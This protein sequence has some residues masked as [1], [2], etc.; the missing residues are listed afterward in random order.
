[1]DEGVGI[2]SNMAYSKPICY[3][4]AAIITAVLDGH[5]WA[6]GRDVHL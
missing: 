5:K 6:A 4:R 1:M 2:A 3:A